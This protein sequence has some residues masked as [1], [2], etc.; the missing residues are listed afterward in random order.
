[1]FVKDGATGTSLR[2]A[3]ADALQPTE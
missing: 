3:G 1:M 2:I